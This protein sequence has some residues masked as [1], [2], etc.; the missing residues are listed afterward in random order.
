MTMRLGLVAGE[1]SGD[2]IA[3]SV[4]RGLR[5]HFSA[6]KVQGI[7]GPNLQAEGMELWHPM[8]AL[9]VFGYV[10]A[11][12]SL[13][14]L[15]RIYG[16]VSQ[17]WLETPP[18]VFIGVDAPDFNLRLEEK[19]HKKGIP[20]VH[21]VSPSIWAWRYERIHQIRRAVSRML[22]LLPFEQAIYEKEGIPVSYVGHPMADAIELQP[23]RLAA[24]AAL[25]ID[26][27]APTVALM[28]GS[29][30]SEVRLMA[31]RFLEAAQKL[32]AR[33]PNMVFLVPM[34]NAA[35]HQEFIKHFSARPVPN[36]RILTA[37]NTVSDRPLSWQVLAACD[38]AMVTSG[39]ATLEAAL[40][41][42]PMVISYVLSP[43][44][45]RIMAWKSGQDRPSLPWVGLPN[46]L[47]QSFIVPELLQD[48]AQP[49]RLAETFW[50]LWCDR[51]RRLAIEARF[52]LIHET[53]RCGTA[54]RV[55]EAIV[56]LVGS[57]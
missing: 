31:P 53:L 4:V 17:R 41:K 15:L 37:G 1:P 30:S 45:R 16:D 54:Q 20:T 32:H 6:L 44:M 5:S 55:T 42:R 47:A 57:R 38:M 3:S 12:K 27:D 19:L 8:N 10:D 29:R 39:T 21:F 11:L 25:G 9:S 7:G 36:L 35:R 40:F 33:E 43:W 52:S 14:R 49:E 26:S 22:V 13:P 46:V 51:D 28:P 48:D 2:L 24:R 18:D 34:V 50:E 23:D 56:D